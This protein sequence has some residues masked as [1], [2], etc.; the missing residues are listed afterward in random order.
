MRTALQKARNICTLVKQRETL[1][2]DILLIQKQC[3]DRIL[4]PVST[5]GISVIEKIKEYI[6][7][8]VLGWTR[9]NF[10]GSPSILKLYLIISLLLKILWILTP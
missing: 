9:I 7:F 4:S 1:K 6:L 10:S 2:Q 3:L 8:K 5:R